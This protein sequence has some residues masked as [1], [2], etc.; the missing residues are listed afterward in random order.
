M[1]AFGY[2]CLWKIKARRAPLL[3][4]IF[5]LGVTCVARWQSSQVSSHQIRHDIASSH[6]F[7]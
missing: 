7:E 6:E 2:N 3:F 1:K 5:N 4:A